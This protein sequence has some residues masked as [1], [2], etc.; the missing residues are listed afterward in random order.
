MPAYFD[1]KPHLED[2]LE[3]L[4]NG[5]SVRM[6]A[7]D[8]GIHH[9]TLS[10]KLKDIGYSVPTREQSAKH[11]W[12]NH[13]HPYKGKKGKLCPHY[14]K[15][16]SEEAKEKRKPLWERLASSKRLGRKCTSG[17]YIHIYEP[18]HPL[19]Y[20]GGYVA[21]HR[22]VMEKHLGRPLT[23]DEIV[24]H[25]N[26]NKSDN[27]IENLSLETRSSHAKIHNNLGRI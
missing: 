5:I 11:I 25:I 24:H 23:N 27:R 6:I 8:L 18:S 16:L 3:K 9:K 14:G 1:I 13:T 15:R 2:V 26:G 21:E 7:K 17:G 12:E 22:L 4:K 20:K 10:T 19:G